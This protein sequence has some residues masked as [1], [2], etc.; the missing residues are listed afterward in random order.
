MTIARGG[1]G[2]VFGVTR[3]GFR[4]PSDLDVGGDVEKPELEVVDGETEEEPVLPFPGLG[5]I[6]IATSTVLLYAGYPSHCLPER[7]HLLHCGL[8]SSHFTLRFL[9]L[10]QPVLTFGRLALLA[11]VFDL[12]AVVPGSILLSARPYTSLAINQPLVA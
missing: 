9:Q 6:G 2:C 3:A 1:G 11:F 8:V 4:T 10:L 12:A 5:A 7:T